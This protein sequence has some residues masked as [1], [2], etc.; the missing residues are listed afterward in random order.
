MVAPQVAVVS[1]V[2]VVAVELVLGH[3]RQAMVEQGC[4]FPQQIR[5]LVMTQEAPNQL[6]SSNRKNPWPLLFQHLSCSVQ[7]P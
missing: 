5:Y 1:V 7:N 4:S 2:V 3:L 6:Q